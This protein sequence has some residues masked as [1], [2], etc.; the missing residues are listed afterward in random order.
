[1]NIQ[2]TALMHL[3][4]VVAG[5]TAAVI[6]EPPALAQTSRAARFDPLN[7]FVGTWAAMKPNE[8]TPYLVL[9]LRESS[10]KLIGTMSHFKIS[11]VGNGR[12]VGSPLMTAET[13]VSNLTV[14]EDELDFTWSGDSPLQGG[15]VRLFIEGTEVA[16]LLIPVST[17]EMKKIMADSPGA[18]GFTPVIWM[19]REPE[20]G[21]ETQREG[22]AKKWEIMTTARLINAAE[23]SYRFKNGTYAD[24]PTLVRSGELQKTGARKFTLGPKTLDSETNPLPGYL[25][26]LLVSPDGTSYQFSILEKTRA[27]CAPG[28]Y[29]DETGVIFEGHPGECSAN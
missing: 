14:S 3:A 7:A 6:A 8:N 2:R 22:S 26:R 5:V 27:D 24:Y 13:P 11:V 9:K 1:M 29:S 17:E 10:G 28:L 20:A 15:Q 12:I 19:R 25:L 4:C 21:N 18:R 16:Y 23:F